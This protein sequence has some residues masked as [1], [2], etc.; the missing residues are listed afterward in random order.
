MKIIPSFLALFMI[1]SIS[2]S[3]KA[4][5]KVTQ[6]TIMVEGICEMC[7]TRIEEAAYGK[8]VKFAE[9]TNATS[10]LIVAY[11]TEKTS[12]EDIE[13]RIAKKGHTTSHKEA[14]KE[15]YETLPDCCRYE[16]LEKH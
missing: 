13:A 6:D 15:D 14:T 2:Y 12:L 8:G 4:Q 16:Q 1:M 11:N 3:S 10:Q 9:W 5:S 7:K